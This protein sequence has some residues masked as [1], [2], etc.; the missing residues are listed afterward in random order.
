MLKTIGIDR[1]DKYLKFKAI[2]ISASLQRDSREQADETTGSE[3][4]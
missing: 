1:I 4:Q 3:Q 2:I